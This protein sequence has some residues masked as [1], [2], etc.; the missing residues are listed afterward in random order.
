MSTKAQIIADSEKLTRITTTEGM[1]GY[2]QGLEGNHVIGFNTY[3]DAEEF[4]KK[5]GGTITLY[6]RRDGHHFY[7]NKGRMLRP[8]TCD[9]W[10][11]A[12]GDNYCVA[13]NIDEER[14]R[15]AEHARDRIKDGK[16]D[17]AAELIE[18]LREIEE[19]ISDAGPDEI[20]ILHYGEYHDTIDKEMMRYHCD[21]YEHVIGVE[22]EPE[23]EAEGTEVP[24]IDDLRRDGEL[25]STA[26]E[27]TVQ[28][29]HYE[30]SDFVV[31]CD[32]SVITRDEDLCDHPFFPLSR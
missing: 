12:H 32:N 10:L 5:H 27:G 15:V 31:L 20:V 28:L 4:V 11:D 14:E 30:G 7:E 8:L 16:L 21:V 2:P 17:G 13:I 24:S 26:Q 6:T 9:D 1:N 23:E 3:Y 19:R 25:I 29:W 18:A 22:I